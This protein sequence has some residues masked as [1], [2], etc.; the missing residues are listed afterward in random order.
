MAWIKGYDYVNIDQ[1]PKIGK[2]W[3]KSFKIEIITRLG[4]LK[5]FQTNFN[6]TYRMSRK[7][8]QQIERFE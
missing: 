4:V 5:R 3:L 1:C 7:M 2:F 6:T 8:H